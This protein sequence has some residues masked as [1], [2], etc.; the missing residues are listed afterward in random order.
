MNKVYG[1]SNKGAQRSELVV[2][3]GQDPTQLSIL[4]V[5]TK[6]GRSLTVPSELH[7]T[8]TYAKKNV[9]AAFF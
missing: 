4:F 3:S 1:S 9:L 5:F 7:R 8:L 6:A 2:I